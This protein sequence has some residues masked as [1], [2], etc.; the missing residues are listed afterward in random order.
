M[1]E[2]NLL[3]KFYKKEGINVTFNNVRYE[4]IKNVTT[5]RKS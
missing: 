1:R 4:T 2:A 3:N 5:S